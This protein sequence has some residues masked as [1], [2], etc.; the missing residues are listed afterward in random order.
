MPPALKRRPSYLPP[1]VVLR[2]G[3]L[4]IVAS[5]IAF[6]LIF[7]GGFW[8]EVCKSAGAKTTDVGLL[9]IGM[10]V[11]SSKT[12]AIYFSK[13][14]QL[15]LNIKVGSI[16]IHIGKSARVLGV[17]FDLKLSWEKQAHCACVQHSDKSDKED[18]CSKKNFI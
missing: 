8:D 7:E 11:N 17:M 18:P 9:D 10:L 1:Q 13:H 2:L 6:Y 14:E 16:K 3:I 4:C 15:G 5:K 12:E